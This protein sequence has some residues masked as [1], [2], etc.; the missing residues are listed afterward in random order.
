MLKQSGQ[1]SLDTTRTEVAI[2]NQTNIGIVSKA[3]LGK[4]LG[5]RMDRIIIGFSERIE[6]I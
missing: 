3:T 2:V 1:A 4:L 6:T 5:N